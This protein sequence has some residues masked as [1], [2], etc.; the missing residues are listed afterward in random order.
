MAGGTFNGDIFL[1]MANHTVS[2]RRTCGQRERIPVDQSNVA[3]RAIH[4]FRQVLAMYHDNVPHPG[5]VLDPSMASQT[6][7]VFHF[8]PDRDNVEA[9]GVKICFFEPSNM[10][11]YLSHCSRLGMTLHTVELC[12]L[13]VS[14]IGDFC[15]NFVTELAERRIR[16]EGIGT[17]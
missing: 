3:I 12:M 4:F 16:R 10:G 1:L 6:D 8:R 7:V 2:F 14:P 9:S 11:H 17:D 5:G 15:R 13:R